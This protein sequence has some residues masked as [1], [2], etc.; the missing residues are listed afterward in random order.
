MD[1]VAFLPIMMLRK[2]QMRRNE[3]VGL[4]VVFAL[5]LLDICFTILRVVYTLS[6]VFT[7][8]SDE[9]TLWVSL[10]PIVAVL[11]CTL[12]CYRNLVSPSRT[13]PIAYSSKLKSLFISNGTGKTNQ[14]LS[15]EMK[16]ASVE[17]LRSHHETS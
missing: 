6:S 13:K 15:T 8:V 4:A 12:P 16:P 2:L 9:N 5:V 10:D 11:V 1:L 17:H 14:T 7:K 3:K